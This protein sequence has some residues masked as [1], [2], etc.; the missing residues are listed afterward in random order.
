[1]DGDGNGGNLV[2]RRGAENSE[3]KK[4]GKITSNSEH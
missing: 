2:D 1:M 4:E 3:G